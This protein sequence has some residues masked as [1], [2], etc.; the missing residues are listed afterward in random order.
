VALNLGNG[1]FEMIP[2]PPEVQ[3]SSVTDIWCGDLNGDGRKDLVMA[4]NDSGFIP[5]LSKLDA[6][7]GH[8][9]LNQGG[10]QYAWIPCANSGFFLRGEVKTLAMVVIKGKKHLISTV[11]GS[12]PRL[13]KIQ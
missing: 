10:G 9:L 11:N 13:F 7:Y 1:Q 5:Q 2:L 12:K 6:S 3:F 8:T 4:G